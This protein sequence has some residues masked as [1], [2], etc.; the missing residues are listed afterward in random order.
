[1][2]DWLG[3]EEYLTE[4][5][6]HRFSF[7]CHAHIEMKGLSQLGSCFASVSK[8]AIPKTGDHSTLLVSFHL[9]R[10][11]G[12]FVIQ[13]TRTPDTDNKM[14]QTLYFLSAILCMCI[15]SHLNDSRTK[16]SSNH[17]KPIKMKIRYELIQNRDPTGK[18][19]NWA[20][21]VVEFS[22]KMALLF[23]ISSKVKF[24]KSYWNCKLVTNK[25]KSLKWNL[26]I[27]VFIRH[28]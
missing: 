14:I 13:V 8:L 16:E 12:D 11:M 25:K 9:K 23:Y 1:M 19:R 21:I 15:S 27:L 6:S 28:K 20:P 7:L 5:F 24:I 2:S 10:H 17:N 4:V 3:S 26:K 22:L 18:T